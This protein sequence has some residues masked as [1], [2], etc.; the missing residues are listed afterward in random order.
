[1]LRITIHDSPR[2]LT[3]HLEGR[4]AGPWLRELEECWQNALAGPHKPIL[5]VDLT[6]MTSISAAGKVCLAALRQQGA[7]FL[8]D[9]CL[10]KAIVAEIAQESPTAETAAGRNK[11]A[12]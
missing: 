11:G 5:R 12:T 4:L 10:M 3:F 6:G 9:D 8:A 7:E 1:M 2:T